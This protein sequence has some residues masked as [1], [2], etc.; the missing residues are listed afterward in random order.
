MV[1]PGDILL[2]LYMD[3]KAD[4]VQLSDASPYST[5][6]VSNTSILGNII[7]TSPLGNV[8]YS[9]TNFTT[10]NS[11]IEVH[12]GQGG[13]NRL[14]KNTGVAIPK[15]GNGL[16]LKGTYTFQYTIQVIENGGSPYTVQITRVFT[17]SHLPAIADVKTTY[18]YFKLKAKVIDLTIYP[19]T[20]VIETR[21]LSL[22]FPLGSGK[23]TITAPNAAIEVSSQSVGNYQGILDVTYV[24]EVQT[25]NFIR[26]QLLKESVINVSG[27]YNFCVV[28]K[29]LLAFLS[30]FKH[31]A[32]SSGGISIQLADKVNAV[33]LNFAGLIMSQGCNSDDFI[34][35][36]DGL[37]AALGLNCGCD[38]ECLENL[39]TSDIF[40]GDGSLTFVDSADL[41]FT[42]SMNQVT[43]VLKANG[44]TA[45][46]YGTSGFYSEITVDATGRVTSISQHAVPVGAQGPAGPTGATGPTGPTGPQG[47]AGPTGPTGATGATGPQ[48]VAGSNGIDA[49]APVGAVIWK[50]STNTPSGYLRCNGAV[51]SRTTYAALFADIGIT[52]GGGDGI[53]TF[54]LPNTRGLFFRDLDSGANIDPGR[55]VGSLQEDAIK[56]HTHTTTVETRDLTNFANVGVDLTMGGGPGSPDAILETDVTTGNP[57]TRPINIAF[58]AFIKY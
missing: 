36:F 40:N 47:V 50:A 9:N 5:K 4:R 24:D 35:Y 29:A 38:D 18:D 49:S 26:Y 54:A 2:K 45:G 7:V 33:N 51:V 11:D 46:T 42:Q 37:Y 1:T 27:K 48:G 53:S 20:G 57:E 55:Q 56:D 10:G 13:T 31:Q 28:E 16:F 15:D 19:S 58:V 3:T 39:Y 21:V 22:V 43:A 32:T 44:V 52:Y 34:T 14:S 30:N 41:H 25:N 17:F 8:I 12:I 23:T 6:V